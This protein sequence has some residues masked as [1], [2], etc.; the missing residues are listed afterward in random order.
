MDIAALIICSLSNA[1]AISNAALLPGIA[2]KPRNK[3]TSI[4]DLYVVCV[5]ERHCFL[6]CLLIINAFD[7]LR[8]TRILVVSFEKRNLVEGQDGIL[9]VTEAG[10][11][12]HDG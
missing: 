1:V 11:A 10:E 6:D 3:T 7:E 2:G 9:Q 4:Q 8:R 12:D 5:D